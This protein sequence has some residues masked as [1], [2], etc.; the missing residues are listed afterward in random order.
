MSTPGVDGVLQALPFFQPAQRLGKLLQRQTT[1]DKWVQLQSTVEQ[2]FA[3]PSH[4]ARREMEAA[5]HTDL[6]I[7]QAVTVHRENGA[8]RLTAEEQ[9]LSARQRSR[10]RLLPTVESP[11]AFDHHV[12]A[13]HH[14][15]LLIQ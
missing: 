1:A 10:E 12:E 4:V 7:V 15:Q 14:R 8:A 13:L 6:L 5:P 11:G 9:H 3:R 2:E